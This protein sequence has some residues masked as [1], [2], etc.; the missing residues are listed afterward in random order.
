MPNAIAN[1][2]DCTH[3][4]KLFLEVT[5]RCNLR[6]KMCVKQSCDTGIASGDLTPATFEALKPAL[7]GLEEVILSGVGEPLLHPLLESFISEMKAT[8]P[9]SAAV[10]LQTNGTLLSRDRIERLRAAELDTI[11]ISVDA[12]RPA[13]LNSIR[14]GA[15]IEQL[16]SALALL[17][18]ARNRSQSSRLRVGIQF[19]LMRDNIRDLPQ[20]LGWANGF[21]V[22]FAIVSHLLPFDVAASQQAAYSSNSDASTELFNQWRQKIARAGLRIEDYPAAS[23]KFY[24]CRSAAEKKLIQMVAAMKSEGCRKEIFMD[25]SRLMAPQADWISQVGPIFEEAATTAHVLGMDLILPARQ[26]AHARQC[27]FLETGSAFVA[28][29]GSVYPC[30]FIWHRYACYPE[31]R[32]KIVQPLSFGHLGS[33]PLI[34]IWNKPEFTAFRK[35]V[36]LYDFPYC[37]DCGLSPCDYIDG[38]EFEQDC[39]TNTVPC[40]DCP[41]PTGILNCLS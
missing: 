33:M 18:A 16:E 15:Q 23:V 29:D 31:G 24:K 36:R 22:D 6:C 26:P 21:G 28:W 20:V 37:G 39:H 4:S 12:V 5:T 25:L 32:K 13:M 10:G 17:A 41:W 1:S 3:P 34:D 7:A 8:L 2:M 38:P 19:V 40:C 14:G 27:P 9:S 30:H 11:C 35:S